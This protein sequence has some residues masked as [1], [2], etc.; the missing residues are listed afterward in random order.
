[1]VARRPSEEI[2]PANQMNDLI[3]RLNHLRASD[4]KRRDY[5]PVYIPEGDCVTYYASGELCH[6]K[7]IDG[8]ITLYI[9]DADPNKIIGCHIKGVAKL[10]R[11]YGPFGVGIATQPQ[12]IGLLFIAARV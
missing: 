2:R 3:E 9:S 10:L 1:M 7:R 4:T 6:A 12:S 5:V 8:L 11:R